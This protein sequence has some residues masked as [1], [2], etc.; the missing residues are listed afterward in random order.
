[1]SFTA[2]IRRGLEVADVALGRWLVRPPRT[3]PFLVCLLTYRCNMRCRMCDC[4]R[5]PRRRAEEELT[6][7]EWKAV[8]DQ[9]VALRTWAASFTGGETLLRDDLEELVRHARQRGLRTHLCTNGLLL[10]AERARSLA[11]A[12]L[13][14]VNVSLDSPRPEVHDALR[15]R[16]VFQTILAN[17]RTFRSVAPGVRLGIS[18]VVTRENYRGLADIVDLSA[19]LGARSVRFAPIHTNL[20]HHR[21]E[22]SS[23]GDLPLRPEDLREVRREVRRALAAFR[24]TGLHRGSRPFLQGIGRIALGKRNTGCVAGFATA[25]VDPYGWV[26]PCPDIEG[27][28]NVREKPL[29]EVWRSPRFQRLRWKVR[30]CRRPCW[31]TSYAE[32]SL[33]FSMRSTLTDPV[34]FIGELNFYLG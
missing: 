28:E 4:W 24:R 23:F 6:T 31:D 27:T 25:C 15:G 2:T 8:I 18:C 33:R 32:L 29:T 3:M 7:A 30:N 22:P 21:M 11:C 20:L 13:G 10:T 14:S 34:Q 19:S 17:V 9:G 16:Q 1:M 26:S 12:G 5:T